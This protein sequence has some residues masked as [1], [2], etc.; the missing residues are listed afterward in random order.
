MVHAFI[1]PHTQ[2]LIARLRKEKNLTHAEIAQIAGVA[3]SS[4]SRILKKFE[5]L[6]SNEQIQNTEKK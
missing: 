2:N 6:Q 4:V 3:K 1:Q 5:N